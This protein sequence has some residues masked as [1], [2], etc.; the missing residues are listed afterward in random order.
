[1]L[2]MSRVTAFV[3]RRL[4]EFTATPLAK[5]ERA[6]AESTEER[7]VECMLELLGTW[8]VQCVLDLEHHLARGFIAHILEKLLSLLV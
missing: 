4:K 3:A 1:M 2:T 6:S 5:R 7:K 8:L